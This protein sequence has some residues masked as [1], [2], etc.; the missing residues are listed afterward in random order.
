MTRASKTGCASA[1]RDEADAPALTI[2]AAE[3]ERRLAARR[4]RAQRP[5]PDPDGR[6]RSRS[7][8]SGR[9]SPSATA[10][11]GCRP[12]AAGESVAGSDACPSRRSLGPSVRAAARP[13]GRRIPPPL[14]G[15][16]AHADG[17]RRVAAVPTSPRSRSS[18]R[19]RWRPFI[20]RTPHGATTCTDTS[21]RRSG[22][23][24]RASRLVTPW[25]TA[26]PPVAWRVSSA[27]GGDRPWE[28]PDGVR[29]EPIPGPTTS[30]LQFLGADSSTASRASTRPRR[31]RRTVG[32]DRVHGRRSPPVAPGAGRR[33]IELGPAGRRDVA[34]PGHG[35]VRR[36][37]G[38]RIVAG[39]RMTVPGERPMAAG[40]QVPLGR[41]R[42]DPLV[43]SALRGAIAQLGEHLH[44][45][46]G[47][48]GSS[49]RSSTIDAT[50]RRPSPLADGG[51]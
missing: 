9:W 17:P 13:A 20:D 33:L 8:R 32:R 25:G 37:T 18:D 43:Q 41:Q 24:S 30:K 1:L 19:R 11:C 45:M 50:N 12:S 51:G 14:A 36:R 49:P 10:G 31:A 39:R 16:G 46:Q 27:S 6:R 23:P 28:A 3:L 22:V 15:A 4:R 48:R 2:T 29:P 40:E 5:A 35:R 21:A 38:R 42:P 26:R 7:S 47:V 44:G 34:H